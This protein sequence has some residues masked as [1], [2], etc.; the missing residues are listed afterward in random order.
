MLNLLSSAPSSAS[1]AVADVP[2]GGVD[3]PLATRPSETSSEV[4]GEGRPGA[5]GKLFSNLLTA[6]L[7]AAGRAK[8]A[9]QDGNGLPT[10]ALQEMELGDSIRLI[11]PADSE[12]PPEDTLFA[13]AV[14]QGLD[15]ALV[16]SVL[17]PGDTKQE[18]DLVSASD[19]ASLALGD[20]T[21][22]VAALL[23]SVVTGQ[24]STTDGARAGAS[25]LMA[26]G[27]D[28]LAVD[29]GAIN[30]TGVS[31]ATVDGL[32]AAA[33]EG[34]AVAPSAS[35]G[36]VQ[37]WLT[38]LVDGMNN[39]A[40]PVQ[41]PSATQAAGSDAS[42]LFKANLAD[43]IRG[44]SPG[45]PSLAQGANS[46]PAAAAIRIQSTEAAVLV[47]TGGAAAG[48]AAAARVAPSLPAQWVLGAQSDRGVA[49]NTDTEERSASAA[50]DSASTSDVA[51]EGRQEHVAHSS[52]R[53]HSSGAGRESVQRDL[54]DL[55]QDITASA[56]DLASDDTE[57]SKLSRKL[58]DGIAQRMVA[59]LAGDNLRL[60]I[61]LKP[62]HLG[63]VSIEMN[64]VRGQ[65]EAVFDAA[66]PAARALISDG[67]ERLR[68]DLQKSGT[69]V[70]FLSMNSGAGG[71]HGGKSTSQKREGGDSRPG[72]IAEVGEVQA[73][74]ATGA[75]RSSDGLDVLV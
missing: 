10:P 36:A 8:L 30:V 19:T 72:A 63:H 48:I 71:G 18:S 33:S 26:I 5:G 50:D 13:F 22:A 74:A 38:G 40:A 49:N 75:L 70:A 73:G 11:T 42:G 34:S 44:Q 31:P 23:A 51:S 16:A 64:M 21:A 45:N 59:A 29:G 67:F 61:D 43:L 25:L 47:A 20:S 58:A 27:V 68:Q 62:A 12:S 46:N 2:P 60:R 39:E 57:L 14:G 55:T 3:S 66:N 4:I 15:A 1:S 69:N 24:V 41:S 28:P 32:A 9:G 65:V 7:G 35:V 17:W 52:H 54:L 6:A 56:R 37:Q 53:T